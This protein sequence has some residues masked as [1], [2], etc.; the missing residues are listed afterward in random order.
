MS[1]FGV[2]RTERGPALTFLR[3]LGRMTVAMFVGMFAF[4]LALALAAPAAGSSLDSVRLSHP[5]LFMLGMVS[6]MTVTMT[7]WML[8]RRHSWREASEMTAAMVVPV[9]A[10][11]ALYWSGAITADP[12]CPLSCALMIPAMAAA[13][14]FRRDAYAQTS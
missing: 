10:V 7:A 9:L 4:G 3:H 12:I 13:M 8:R 6:A 11:F 14:L 1:T 5:E 2:S